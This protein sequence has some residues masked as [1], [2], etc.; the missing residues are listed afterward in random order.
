MVNYKT[1][2]ETGKIQIKRF[3]RW[4]SKSRKNLKKKSNNNENL[5]SKQTQL[6][7][8][9]CSKPA[10]KYKKPSIELTQDII[11]DL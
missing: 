1:R 9:F 8:Y 11:L 3:S 7:F 2:E 4:F 6:Y 5:D 10:I